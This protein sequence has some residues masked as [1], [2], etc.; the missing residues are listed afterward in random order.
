MITAGLLAAGCFGDGG[1]GGDGA[2]ESSEATGAETGAPTTGGAE[3]FPECDAYLACV[4]ET[5]PEAYGGALEL[6]GAGSDCR[7]STEEVAAS[8]EQACRDARAD[9]FVMY[10]DEAACGDEPGSGVGSVVSGF[11]QFVNAPGAADTSVVLADK[12]SFDPQAAH[13]AVPDGPKVAH[14]DGVWSIPGVADG[15]YWVLVAFGDDALVLD[16]DGADGFP[17]VV[18]AGADVEVGEV[19][20]TGAMTVVSPTA[21][22]VVGSSPT[23]TWTDVSAEDRY[24]LRVVDAD[25]IVV[26]SSL[27]L[28]AVAG[29]P[30]VE[31]AYDGNGLAPGEYQFRVIAFSGQTAL[32]RTEDLAGTFVVQ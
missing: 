27:E 30:T 7:N 8:C 23:F 2:G 5:M 11:V 24:E 32:T 26:W 25:G 14:T 16:P 3:V 29:S 28:P 20:V 18:V 19:K 22:A 4:L 9:L 21:G 15:E 17:T 6:Y 31:V 13:F 10:P 1:G 12:K